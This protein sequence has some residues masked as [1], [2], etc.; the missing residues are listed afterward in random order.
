M[1]NLWQLRSAIWTLPSS[2]C[3]TTSYPDVQRLNLG[4]RKY[5]LTTLNY[6]PQSSDANAGTRDSQLRY[7]ATLPQRPLKFHIRQYSIYLYHRYTATNCGTQTVALYR[8]WAVLIL[9]HCHKEKL[10]VGGGGV[11]ATLVRTGKKNY[12]KISH[13]VTISDK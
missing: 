12:P 8:G 9:Q 2:Q 5:I 6:F 7:G 3:D 13:G 4:S 11:T 10:C 1:Q